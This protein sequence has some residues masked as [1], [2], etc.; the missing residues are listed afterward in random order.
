MLLDHVAAKARPF[1]DAQHPGDASDHAANHATNHA[2]D[3]S[4]GTFAVTRA[5]L[6]PAWDPLGLCQRGQR[7]G[8][9]KGGHSD[10]TLNH[11]CS[12]VSGRSQYK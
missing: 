6:N 8:G 2:S 7:Q 5:S 4:G 10:K 1:V 3:G 9:D 11:D 12:E